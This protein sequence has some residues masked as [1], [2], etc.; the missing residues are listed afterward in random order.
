NAKKAMQLFAP[1]SRGLVL[2]GLLA[3]LTWPHGEN[4]IEL[5]SAWLS[6]QTHDLDRHHRLGD[7]GTGFQLPGVFHKLLITFF[8]LLLNVLAVLP[9]QSQDKEMFDSP[10]EVAP[11]HHLKWLR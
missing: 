6:V 2:T 5:G 11:A 1:R 3:W 7:N 8:D 4:G 10:I 9:S